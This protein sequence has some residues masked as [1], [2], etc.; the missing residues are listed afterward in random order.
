MLH[1]EGRELTDETMHEGKQGTLD[2]LMTV[3][4]MKDINTKKSKLSDLDRIL[5]ATQDPP[6]PPAN[7]LV[8]LL[9]GGGLPLPGGL[10]TPA[11]PIPGPLPLP[12]PSAGAGALPFNAGPQIPAQQLASALG[13]RPAPRPSPAIEI[14]K[15]IIQNKSGLV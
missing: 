6:Q 14:A 2:L 12:G 13:P 5:L 3:L 8:A 11:G 10:P 9:G 4:R 15:M 7:P 1:G